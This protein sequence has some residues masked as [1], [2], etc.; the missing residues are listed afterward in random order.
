MRGGYA[1]V[2]E[3][4]TISSRLV[5]KIM[6]ICAIMLSTEQDG[7]KREAFRG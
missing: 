5:E 1:N 3:Q 2:T 6:K 4:I 7:T